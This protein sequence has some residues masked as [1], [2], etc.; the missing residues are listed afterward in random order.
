MKK[1]LALFLLPLAAHAQ[2]GP[3][4]QYLMGE[5]ATLFDVGMLR[6]DA[7]TTEF[8]QRV[9]LSWAGSNGRRE[10]FKAEINSDY[11][12]GADKIYVSFLVMN[13]DA[14]ATQMQ[15]G[16]GVA[17]EQMSIWLLKSLPGL[18]LHADGNTSTDSQRLFDGLR[19]MFVLRCY[20]SSRYDTS[21]GR[22][23]ASRTLRDTALT[24]GRWN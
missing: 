21:E 3:T 24:I 7:L 16:C 8:A 12:A 13:S 4:T 5:S 10:F 9:G 15:E 2:P 19:D 23:W 1:L 11:D 14:T 22:F 18:F 20:V 17:T 6:L